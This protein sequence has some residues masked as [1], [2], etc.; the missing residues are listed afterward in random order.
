MYLRKAIT[1][2]VDS[3]LDLLQM[4]CIKFQMLMYKSSVKVRAKWQNQASRFNL[5]YCVLYILNK[6]TLGVKKVQ[7][8]SEATS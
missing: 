2:Q 7:G 3:N 5:H 4:I 8:Q 1:L 6:N